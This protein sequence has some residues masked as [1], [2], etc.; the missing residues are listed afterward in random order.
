MIL[1]KAKISLPSVSS[2]PLAVS[3]PMKPVQQAS[4]QKKI[5]ADA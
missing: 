4:M 5:N 1:G 3:A 2:A